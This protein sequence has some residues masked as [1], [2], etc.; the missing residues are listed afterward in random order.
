MMIKIVHLM[1]TT[2]QSREGGGTGVVDLGR[3]HISL[4]VKLLNFVKYHC[5][6]C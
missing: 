2:P 5:L 4:I 1:K 6:Y 3:F